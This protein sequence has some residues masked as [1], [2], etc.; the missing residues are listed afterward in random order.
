MAVYAGEQL[1]PFTKSHG[2]TWFDPQTGGIW[3][4]WTCSGFTLAFTGKTLRARVMAFGD[5]VPGP[6]GV[7]VLT[8]Y[9]CLGVA[10][11]DGEA[12]SA[13]FACGGGPQWY[14]L[15]SGEEGSHTLRLVKLSENMRGKA[16]LLALET[17]GELLAPQEADK[18][19]SIEFVGDSITCGYGNEAPGP[20]APFQTAEENGW[21]TYGAL[22][23]R[24]LEAEFSMVSVSGI[25]AA[26]AKHP[27]LPSPQM[28][29]VYPF[30]DRYGYERLELEP[31]PWD[32]A[33]HPKDLVVINLGTND[34]NPIRF[35]KDTAAAD[36]EEAWF[37]E[38]YRAFVEKVR[39][40]NGPDTAILGHSLR[41]GPYGLLPVRQNPAD[42][43]RLSKGHRR[44]AGF[45]PEAHRHQP[46]GRGLWQRRSPLPENPHPHGPGAGKAHPPAGACITGF[47]AFSPRGVCL[48]HIPRFF[49][50]TNQESF[51]KWNKIESRP[52]IFG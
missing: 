36:Q 45:L 11:Q 38:R 6:P 52:V 4:N 39:R 27:F 48:R 22:A 9:P 29:E 14:P 40:L 18:R 42:G 13:R 33:A 23:A 2:R 19:L 34:V 10:V 46:D 47:S 20:E 12:L 7:P 15:F 37:V 32:F 50:A 17:D 44:P 26:R 8:D 51:S 25:A 3:F 16:C 24:E 28:E 30:T 5:Q 21:M 41:A 43:G 35:A 31:L 49:P 1:L